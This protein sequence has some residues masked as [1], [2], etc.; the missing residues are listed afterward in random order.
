MWGPGYCKIIK[1][2]DLRISVITSTSETLRRQLCLL[3]KFRWIRIIQ[4]FWIDRVGKLEMKKKV[5]K[6]NLNEG[7]HPKKIW[8]KH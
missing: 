6:I 2:E 1:E 8:G 4:V 7:K 5:A 3:P